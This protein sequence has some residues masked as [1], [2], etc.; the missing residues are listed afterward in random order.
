VCADVFFFALLRIAPRGSLLLCCLHID[1]SDSAQPLLIHIHKV[2]AWN[3]GIALHRT[4]K[5]EVLI[6]GKERD[7]A[8]FPV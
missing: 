2:P 3:I 1:L 4:R 7:M 5:E 6:V 8:M